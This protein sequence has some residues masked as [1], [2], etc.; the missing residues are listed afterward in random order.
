MLPSL[1]DQ[2]PSLL[3]LMD[4]KTLL[5]TILFYPTLILILMLL[6]QTKKKVQKSKIIKTKPPQRGTLGD[7]PFSTLSNK[8]KTLKISLG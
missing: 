2:S 5:L 6:P 4:E 8:E 3:D 1:R 7:L